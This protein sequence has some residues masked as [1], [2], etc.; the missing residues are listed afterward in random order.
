[1]SKTFKEVFKEEQELEKG[2]ADLWGYSLAST[3]LDQKQKRQKQIS[4]PVVANITLRK[5]GKE[6]P[7]TERIKQ[8]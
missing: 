8:V 6:I 2:L 1:M 3:S 4:P 7:K 5:F